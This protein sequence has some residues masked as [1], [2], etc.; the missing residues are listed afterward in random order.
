MA[1]RLQ[2]CCP[3]FFKST[4]S[5]YANLAIPDIF[6]VRWILISAGFVKPEGQKS[7]KKTQQYSFWSGIVLNNA[8]TSQKNYNNETS[9]AILFVFAA[10]I[11]QQHLQQTPC[12]YKANNHKTSNFH[13]YIFH[14]G[15]RE[16]IMIVYKIW[17]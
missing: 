8:C 4:L 6:L 15:G 3:V 1:V 2:F 13:K 5:D 7:F 12:K 10:L 11:L 17:F 9:Y 16:K 14:F